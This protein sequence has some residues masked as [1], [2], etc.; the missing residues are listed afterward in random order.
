MTEPASNVSPVPQVHAL[1]Y[2]AEREYTPTGV[3]PVSAVL[4]TLAGGMLA[5]L[6]GAV[7]A[8]VWIVSGLRSWLFFPLLLQGLI[9]GGTLAWLIR[10]FQ[11]RHRSASVLIALVCGLTSAAFFHGGLYVR[12]VYAFRDSVRSDW[13][14]SGSDLRYKL[15]VDY[16]NAHPFPAFDSVLVRRTG[17]RG[18]LGYMILRGWTIIG[19]AILQIV[20]V[21]WIAIK[22]A[23]ESASTP[24]CETCK[25]WF[26][27]PKNAAVL[28]VVC[29]DA[30]SSAITS[31]D[32]NQVLALHHSAGRSL[33][34]SCVIARVRECPKCAK[35]Y[36][37][38]IVKSFG[39]RGSSQEKVR[40]APRRVSPEMVA[41]LRYEPPQEVLAVSTNPAS[42][43]TQT[44]QP[45][46]A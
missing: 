40:M 34:S 28:P 11:L 18:F 6:A 8:F 16:M 26:G 7:A 39:A 35:Q 17:H 9:V 14:Q 13:V 4:F 41:A 22:F 32:P 3:A 21:A 10:K 5:A 36:A 24:F 31:E 38:V 19:L 37:D 15:A 29:G 33:G 44:P 42:A 20:V 27:P 30:L 43:P 45:N 46:Q 2:P 25:T 23:K 12:N 1:E